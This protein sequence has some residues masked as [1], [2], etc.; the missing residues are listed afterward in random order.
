MHD[1]QELARQ[2]RI[3]GD[4]LHLE[5]SGTYPLAAEFD[6]I[7]VSPK[8]FKPMLDETLSCADEL[9]VVVYNTSDFSWAEKQQ[10]KVP[11]ACLLYLQPEWSKE[12]EMMPGILDYLYR[13]PEWKLSVQLHKYLHIP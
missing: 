10:A 5:T 11:A 12:K 6:W 1:I 3:A 7:C 9:K 13:H 8:K 4:R 2:I